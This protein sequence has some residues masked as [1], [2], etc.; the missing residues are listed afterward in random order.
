MGKQFF[1]ART[2]MLIMDFS[3]LIQFMEFV[4]SE[5]A[6]IRECERLGYILAHS[7]F[8]LFESV[9]HLNEKVAALSIVVDQM[10]HKVNQQT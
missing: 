6:V 1:E 4:Q 3:A 7:L 2:E 9:T 5:F 8:V 10:Y